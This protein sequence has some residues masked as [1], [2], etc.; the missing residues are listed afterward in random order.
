[1]LDIKFLRSVI[2]VAVTLGGAVAYAQDDQ[3]EKGPYDQRYFA[4]TKGSPMAQPLRYKPVVPSV[5]LQVSSDGSGE[6][7]ELI[8][9]LS[10]ES[11]DKFRTLLSLPSTDSSTTNPAGLERVVVSALNVSFFSSC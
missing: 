8:I 2:M 6:T 11:A 3:L 9:L 7:S 1:M 5:D 10:D 4:R